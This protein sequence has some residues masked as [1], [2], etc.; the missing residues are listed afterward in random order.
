MCE[1]VIQSSLYIHVMFERHRS[2]VVGYESVEVQCK[3][4]EFVRSKN[5][6]MWKHCAEICQEYG[7]SVVT[8]MTT[9]SGLHRWL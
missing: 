4:I 2:S 6:Q 3:G 8:E 1:S 9:V 7:Y 5:H